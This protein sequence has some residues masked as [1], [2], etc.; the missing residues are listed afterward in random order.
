[1]KTYK[2][3]LGDRYDG[4]LL[5][6]LD[7]FSKIIPYIMK[8]R[9]DAQNYF[10]E[11]IDINPIEDFLS[12]KRRSGIKDI[13]FLHI[14]IA[15]MV[16]TISQKP[17]INRF[18]AGQRIYA[19][20]EILISLAVKKKLHEDSPETT[21]K[22]SFQPTDTLSDIVAK[23]NVAVRENKKSDVENNTDITARMVMLCPRFLIRFLVWILKILD[24]YGLMPKIINKVSPFHTSVFITDLGSLGIQP[25]YHH[26]YE[27]GTTSLFVAFGTKQKEKILDKDNNAVENRFVNIKVTSDERIVGGHYYATAFKLFRRLM[28]NPKVLENP[29]NKVVEEIE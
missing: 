6:T 15:A 22:L 27:F 8:D 11:K 1:M 12:E 4:R 7:S 9:V 3:R 26:L 13:G 17:R 29:P 21:I 18:I 25:I 2:R 14:V 19:R 28:E 24:Y 16:R 5:R 23:L 20:N 10:D